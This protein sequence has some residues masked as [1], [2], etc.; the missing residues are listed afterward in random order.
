VT[1]EE[2]WRIPRD[3]VNELGKFNSHVNG[4]K[5]GLTAAVARILVSS[6]SE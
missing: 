6:A 3:V 2:A 5:I 4:I 1:V